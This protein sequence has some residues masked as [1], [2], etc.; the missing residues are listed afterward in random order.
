M[1]S[2]NLNDILK[3]ELWTVEDIN[4]APA[5]TNLYNSGI[6][7]RDSRIAKIVNSIDIGTKVEIPFIQIADYAEPNISDDTTNKADVNKWNKIRQMALLGNYNNAWGSYDIARELDSGKDPYI[8]IRDFIGQYWAFDIQHRM[9]SYAIG[10]LEDNKANDNSD[11]YNDQS[12]NEFSYDMVVD[13]NALRGDRGVGGTDFMIMHSK[14]YASIKKEDSGRVRAILDNQNGKILYHLYDERTVIIIDDI[15][16][17]DGT[18]TTVLFANS[19]TFVFEESNNVK[20]P[21]MY[22][23]DE[24]IGSG[25]GHELIISRKRYLLSVNGFSYTGVVQ[26]KSTGATIAELQEPNNHNRV[27]D[28]KLSPICYLTFKA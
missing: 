4:E 9:A 2:Y 7:T 10:I 3:R 26:A 28:K 8:V 6:L 14:A 11:L 19:G 22:E 1:A 17:Y 15:M 16:P 24:L 18:N 5:L 13:T 12:G 27:V 20:N 25:G 23:R 21:L